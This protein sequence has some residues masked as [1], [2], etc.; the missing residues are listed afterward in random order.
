MGPEGLLPCS[1]EPATSPYPESDVSIPHLPNPISLRSS[2]ILTYYHR[3]GLLSF[4]ISD[5]KISTHFSSLHACYIP[6]PSH[7]P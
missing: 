5:K 7:L 6:H 2:L 4:R 3:L 1:Q